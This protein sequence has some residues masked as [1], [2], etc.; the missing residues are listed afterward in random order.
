M[1]ILYILLVLLVL[2]R[3]FGE[4]AVRLGQPA[5][6]GGLIAGIAFGILIGISPGSFPIMGQASEN[7]VFSAVTDLGIFFLMLPGRLGNAS[8]GAG[9]KLQARAVHC[10]GRHAAA[11]C[12]RLFARMALLACIRLSGRPGPPHGR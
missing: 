3:T 6:V 9:R 11:T 2:T 5:L 10:V 1:G 4:L 8:E 7:E 12:R